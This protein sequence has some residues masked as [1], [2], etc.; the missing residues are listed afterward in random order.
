MNVTVKKLDKSKVEL[1]IEAGKDAVAQKYDEIYKQINSEAKIPG[2]RP[3][4]IPRDILEKRFRDTAR[5]MVVE[6]LADDL[7]AQAVKEENI[8]VINHPQ[9]SEV[10]LKGNS[11]SFKAVVEVRPEVKIKKYKGIKIKQ[12]KIELSAEKI[13]E[14]L[15]KIKQEKGIEVL[16]DNFARSLGYPSLSDL[17]EIVRNQLFLSLSEN[18]RHKHEE[19]VADFLIND[20]EVDVPDS[21]IERELKE[22]L[23]M[24]EYR[25][26]QQ[27]MAKEKI[28]EKKKEIEAG[29]REVASRD[30]KLYFILDKI[31]ELENIKLDEKHN[32]TKVMEFL[33]KEAEWAE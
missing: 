1:S 22:R 18:T 32:T 16:D 30:L 25:L 20:S 26:L 14:A 17:K 5:S 29:L 31:A 2:F 3:G 9:I 12:E 33:L 23:H 10:N 24:L 21:V 7:Y 28:E 19:Q 4:K 6:H 27:G 11:F 13:E 15:E 8:F